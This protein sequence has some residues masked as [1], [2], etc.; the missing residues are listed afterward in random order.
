M[1]KHIAALVGFVIIFPMLLIVLWLFRGGGLQ[2][3]GQVY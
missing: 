3:L 1:D 2:M